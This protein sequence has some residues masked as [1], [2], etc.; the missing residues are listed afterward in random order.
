MGADAIIMNQGGTRQLRFRGAPNHLSAVLRLSEAE[1]EM[2]SEAQPAMVHLAGAEAQPLILRPVRNAEPGVSLLKLRLPL[3]TPPGSY[4]GTVEAGGKQLP[5]RVE[6][7]PLPRLRIFP[8]SLALKAAAKAQ[9]KSEFDVVNVGN[10]AIDIA[11]EYSFCVFD[12]AGIE[13]AF[14]AALATNAIKG[15]RRLAHLMDKLAEYHGGLVRVVVEEGIGEIAAGE[16]RNLRFTLIMPE[17]L[18]PGHT[19]SGTWRPFG[20]RIRIETS[21]ARQHTKEI[22]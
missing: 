11:S 16:T 5:V 15:E 14:Y 19:Y 10:V 21:A 8:R 6:V 4:E 12:G 13:H 20:Y 1:T 17:R 18:S 22:K 7:E 2:L 9:L 3:T